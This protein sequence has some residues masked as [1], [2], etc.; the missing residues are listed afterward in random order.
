MT[1]PA[2]S[3]SL[4]KNMA[5]DYG[6]MMLRSGLGGVPQSFYG[7]PLSHISFSAPEL[8]T[9]LINKVHAGVEYAVSFDF[10][11]AQAEALLAKVSP[12]MRSN[13]VSRLSKAKPGSTVVFEVPLVVDLHAR[14]GKLQKSRKEEFV[15]FLVERVE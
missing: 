15:P 12:P 8:Y 7:V 9:S 2:N 3:N 4:E 10:G 6:L 11:P 1:N 14:L 5:P 13:I